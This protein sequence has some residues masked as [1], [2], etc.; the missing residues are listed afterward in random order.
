MNRRQTM[1]TWYVTTGI[2]LWES[3]RCWL[4]ENVKTEILQRADQFSEKELSTDNSGPG[5]MQQWAQVRE[6][7]KATISSANAG[8]KDSQAQKLVEKYFRKEC[9]AID[10]LK[11]LP[12]ELAT[13]CALFQSAMIQTGDTVAFIAGESNKE[14]SHMLKAMLTAALNGSPSVIINILGPYALDPTETDKFNAGVQKMWGEVQEDTNPKAFVLTGGYKAVLIAIARKAPH[15]TLLFYSHESDPARLIP[16]TAQE[17][18]I[19]KAGS[20]LRPSS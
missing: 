12:A 8:D 10:R 17:L 9:W 15:G 4:L 16:L 1:T 19:I 7:I 6:K 18:N 20:P 13:L 2:S 11:A 3:S 5:L 14:V